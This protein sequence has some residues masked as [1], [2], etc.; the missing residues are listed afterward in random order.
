MA[1]IAMKLNVSLYDNPLTERKDDFA[2][3]LI[4]LQK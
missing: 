1:K 2:E 4:I 3:R